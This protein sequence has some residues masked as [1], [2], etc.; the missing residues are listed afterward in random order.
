MNDYTLVLKCLKVW[1]AVKLLAAKTTP[2][3]TIYYLHWHTYSWCR[4]TL[5]PV[6]RVRTERRQ[7]GIAVLSQIAAFITAVINTDQCRS[8]GITAL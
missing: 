6:D 1:K 2:N 4:V 8:G 3:T 5:L 7:S